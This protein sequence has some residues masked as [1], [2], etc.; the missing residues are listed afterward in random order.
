MYRIDPHFIYFTWDLKHKN[1]YLQYKDD[2]LNTVVVQTS[3]GVYKNTYG[4]VL[5]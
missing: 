4:D 2:K 3:V 1:K 5:L